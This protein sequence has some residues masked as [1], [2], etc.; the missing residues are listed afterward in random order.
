MIGLDTNVL[1]RYLTQD[2][3][4]QARRANSFIHEAVAGGERLFVDIVVLYE[5]VWVLTG[6]YGFGRDS[7]ADTLESILETAQLEIGAKDLARLALADY[8]EGKADF[9]D[10]LIGRS[11]QEA[12][13][14]VTATFDRRL[15]GNA[16]FRV[17]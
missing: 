2:D 15:R 3:R 17:L 14:A 11:C 1:I 8:R 13:C 10:Y 12:G 5:L 9:A 4:G 7:V 6:A 16:M